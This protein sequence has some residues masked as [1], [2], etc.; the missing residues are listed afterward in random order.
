MFYKRENP[1]HRI[2]IST[3]SV[4]PW[5][6]TTTMAL[7]LHCPLYVTC[8]IFFFHSSRTRLLPEDVCKWNFENICESSI[9]VFAVSRNTI[10]VIKPTT[11]NLVSRS[12]TQC[13]SVWS[14][15]EQIVRSNQKKNWGQKISG[16]HKGTEFFFSIFIA[17]GECDW[18]I[19]S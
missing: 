5:P 19:R 13:T 14:C 9:S 10:D 7:R 11:F 15:P 8:A 4:Q 16:E 6:G 17:G 3:R 18:E 1:P 12:I 2:K